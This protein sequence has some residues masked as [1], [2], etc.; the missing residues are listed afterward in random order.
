MKFVSSIPQFICIGV[1]DHAPVKPVRRGSFD[2]EMEE[3]NPSK[4]VTPII[5][6]HEAYLESKKKQKPRRCKAPQR[7]ISFLSRRAQSGTDINANP[8]KPVRSRDK[9]FALPTRCRSFDSNMMDQKPRKLQTPTPRTSEIHWRPKIH[10]LEQ[11]RSS[12][13]VHESEIRSFWTSVVT[14]DDADTTLSHSHT[15]EFSDTCS[16]NGARDKQAP[17]KM[18]G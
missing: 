10:Y 3:R 8:I 14:S 11:V 5:P 9:P 12:T 7:A 6:C 17:G 4:T 15:E 2:R 16:C 1:K 13:M 18:P